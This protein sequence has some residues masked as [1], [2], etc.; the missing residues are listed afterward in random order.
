MLGHARDCGS[1]DRSLDASVIL[2][3]L[4]MT[5]PHTYIRL[6]DEIVRPNSA[7]FKKRR[8]ISAPI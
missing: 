4:E 5:P 6:V 3:G 1:R 8:V 2:D 7:G